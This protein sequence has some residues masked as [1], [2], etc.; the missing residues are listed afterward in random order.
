MKMAMAVL[1]AL[2]VTLSAL[3]WKMFESFSIAAER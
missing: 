3:N 2:A 1:A